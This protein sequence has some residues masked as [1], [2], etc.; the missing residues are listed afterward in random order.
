MNLFLVSMPF[1]LPLPFLRLG[2]R[3]P[4]RQSGMH[5]KYQHPARFQ[6]PR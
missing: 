1:C 4:Q 2:L 6:D 5:H 3:L